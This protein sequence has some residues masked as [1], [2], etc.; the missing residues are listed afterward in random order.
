MSYDVTKVRADF[1]ILG[2]SSNGH[3][4]SF[5]DS[6]ASAQKPTA[7]IDAV[8][9]CYET[10]YANIHRGVYDLS[11]RTTASFEA[12]RETVRRYL[13]A[14][15][16]REIIF[17]RGGTE[18]INLV[19]ATYGRANLEAGDEII[20]SHMEHH[21]NIV[22]WQMLRDELGVVLRIAPIDDDGNFLLDEYEK[23][24][25][26]RTKLVAMTHASNALG[27]VVPIKQVTALAHD[28]GAVVLVDG[29][30][31]VVH[32]AVDVQDI[33]CDFYVFSGHKLYGP[34]GIGALYGKAELLE[35][36]P[37]YQGGGEMILSVTFEETEYNV[38]PHKFE[39]GTPNI[40]GAVGLGAAIDYINGLGLDHIAAHEQ[41]VLDYATQ[42]I[43]EYN[44]VRLIGTAAHKAA[45]LS[46]TVEGVHPHDLGT[47]LDSQG[48]AVRAGHHCAQPVM[49]RFGLAATVRA[50]FGVY[51]T[52][53]DADRL[54]AAV[55]QAIE[56]FG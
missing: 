32:M 23:L 38:I 49:E 40:V 36:M 43:T 13:N 11:Q 20:L 7:V 48:V 33:D 10:E 2:Q 28:H 31:A 54:V 19:A 56:I 44:S 47:I 22:P 42:R 24:L 27:T 29:C 4:L 17:V 51:N 41:A 37:A 16:A 3:P 30:Q 35:A 5:L 25:N 14:A 9:G 6:A 26:P 34:S 39:A 18:A 52:T 15:E 55:G 21:S 8:R 53:D 50:S 1:P 12:A 46:F 45:I